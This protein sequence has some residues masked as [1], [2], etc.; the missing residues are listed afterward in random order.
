MPRTTSLWDAVKFE[1]LNVQEDELASEAL[2]VVKAI[3]VHLSK[4]WPDPADSPLS[5][6]VKIITTECNEKLQEPQQK[7]AKQAGQILASVAAASPVAFHFITK[8]V[9]PSIFTIYQDRD[10][11]GKQRSLLEVINQLLESAAEVYG[12]VGAI[13]PVPSL[14]N[15]LYSF[16]D[17]LFELYS[18]ALM[19]T[20]KEEVSFRVVA[21]KGLLQIVKLKNFLSAGEIGMVVQYLNEIVLVE[22]SYSTDEIKEEAIKGLVEISKLDYRVIMEITF[23]AFMSKL[24]DS[25]PEE[26]TYLTVL[27][28]LA[29]LSVDKDVFELLYRRL[30]NKFD[31]VIRNDTSTTYP[32]AILSALIYVIEK[33]ELGKNVVWADYARRIVNGPMQKALEADLKSLIRHTVILEDLGRLLTITLRQID[34]S[35]HQNMVDEIWSTLMLGRLSS[36]EDFGIEGSVEPNG[37]LRIF[38]THLLAGLHPSV[39][40]PLRPSALLKIATVEPRKSAVAA[41]IEALN[42]Q[43]ALLVNKWL[44]A[45]DDTSIT[46]ITDD[47]FSKV[48][49]TSTDFGQARESIASLIYII[50]GLLLRLDRATFRLLDQIVPLVSHPTYGTSTA[51]EFALLLSPSRLL[52]KD[53]FCTIRLLPCSETIHVRLAISQHYFC[54]QYCSNNQNKPPYCTCRTPSSRTI[55]SHTSTSSNAHPPTPARNRLAR[56]K[57]QSSQYLNATD[58]VRGENSAPSKS[59]LEVSYRGF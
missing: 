56:R 6:H 32:H 52:T 16:Q 15:P 21:L 53:N 54:V 49:S 8:D 48:K 58:P 27:E 10:T 9:L 23:P 20:P 51:Q 57:G 35:E 30:V 33:N 25:S 42:V 12:I 47:L 17:R 59:M 41:D 28:G 13:S 40:L 50:K 5:R 55:V 45:K 31:I 24:P 43:S 1:V 2:L 14:E 46:P 22:E 38:L 29:K 26:S 3:A 36:P 34:T 37:C 11:L 4:Y 7:Q 18:R 39:K 44:S 19:G